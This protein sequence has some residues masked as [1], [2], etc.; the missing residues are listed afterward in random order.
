MRGP[1]IAGVF[2]GE[3][4]ARTTRAAWTPELGH[5]LS[6]FERDRRVDGR[7]YRVYC[8]LGE[9]AGLMTAGRVYCGLSE[10]AGLMALVSL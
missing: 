7:W 1:R 4:V 5:G 9:I 3:V 2:E 6:Q 8:G 10:I